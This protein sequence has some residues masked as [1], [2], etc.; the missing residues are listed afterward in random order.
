M[1]SET[2]N[3]LLT[4][5]RLLTASLPI[6][7]LTPD[8]GMGTGTIWDLVSTMAIQTQTPEISLKVLR[9]LVSALAGESATSEI[10]MQFVRDLRT[11]MAAVTA[12]SNPLLAILR[13]LLTAIA[14]ESQTSE[15]GF[16]W[17]GYIPE[18]LRVRALL[19]QLQAE[20]S[21]PA[22]R[23]ERYGS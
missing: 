9:D 13:D 8:I 17:A 6:V 20:L 7:S 5:L 2:S 3:P 1:A 18:H 12:T 11:A 19:S 21:A 14:I 16:M 15:V 10:T 22:L 4:V 23:A